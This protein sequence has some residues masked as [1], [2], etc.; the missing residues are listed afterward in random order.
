M[1]RIDL[2]ALREGPVDMVQAVPA[3]DPLFEQL[4]FQLS[5]PVQLSGR[6][7]E[8]GT[9]R[10]YWH[11]GL[12]TRVKSACRRCLTDLDLAIDQPVEVL[13][14]EDD[15]TDDPAAYSIP[16]HAAELDLREA[17]REELILAVPEYSLCDEGCRGICPTCGTDLNAGTC[18][19]ER[20]PDPRWAGLEELRAA[21]PDDEVS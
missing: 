18:S 19:C 12:R 14:T 21:L 1:L 10:Y 16:Q 17:V 15:G 6:L 2:G 8:A 13:F 20:Q 5:G 4:D 3:D 9:G 11:G 7:M